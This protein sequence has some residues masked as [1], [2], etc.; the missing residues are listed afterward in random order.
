MRWY[1]RISLGL[2]LAVASAFLVAYWRS[3]VSHSYPNMNAPGL[4]AYLLVFPAC[5]LLLHSPCVGIR[6][7]AA[8]AG[9]RSRKSAAMDDQPGAVDGAALFHICQ[10]LIRHSRVCS[11]SKRTALTS[12]AAAEYRCVL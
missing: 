2:S 7:P 5:A 11:S 9:K 6:A 1:S 8:K 3:L 4:I 12:P 10:S